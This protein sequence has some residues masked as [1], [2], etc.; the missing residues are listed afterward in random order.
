[1]IGH[2]KDRF[3]ETRESKAFSAPLAD[4]ELERV[5]GGDMPIANALHQIKGIS[6]DRK[7]PKCGI[8][9]WER[10]ESSACRWHCLACATIGKPDSEVGYIT[11][12]LTTNGRK[13][14]LIF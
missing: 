12:G 5:T 13:I 11:A 9:C 7:C 3:M 2:E 14:T 6:L 8:D 1:M 10:V 4:E